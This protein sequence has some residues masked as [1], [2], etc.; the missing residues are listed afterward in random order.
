MPL[1]NQ[2]HKKTHLKALLF[3]TYILL[4]QF[5]RYDNHYICAYFKKFE[6]LKSVIISPSSIHAYRKMPARRFMYS[7]HVYHIKKIY[8][9]KN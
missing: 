6:Q 9:I 5:N 8:T 1:T 3:N 4:H 2:G 7:I